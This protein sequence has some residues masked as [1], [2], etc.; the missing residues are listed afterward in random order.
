MEEYAPLEE[1]VLLNT[2]IRGMNADA[3]QEAFY[4]VI[5]N[6]KPHVVCL[7]ETKLRYDLYLSNYWA[8]KPSMTA[9]EGAGPPL[10]VNRMSAYN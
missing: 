8:F 4:K 5:G 10:D 6:E 2:N 1:I 3:K 9:K 7:N